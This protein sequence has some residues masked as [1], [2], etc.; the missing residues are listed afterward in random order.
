VALGSRVVAILSDGFESPDIILGD[1]IPI[2]CANESEL[3]RT[4]RSRRLDGLLLPLGAR[5]VRNVEILRRLW[6]EGQLTVAIVADMRP[7]DRVAASQ[8]MELLLLGMDVRPALRLKDVESLR[9][10]LQRL[11]TRGTPTARE[12]LLSSLAPLVPIE[13]TE[14]LVVACVLGGVRRSAAEFSASLSIGRSALRT[15]LSTHGL[16]TPTG[17]LGLIAGF[18]L[19]YHSSVLDMSLV[20]ASRWAQFDSED[21]FRNYLKARTGI[22]PRGWKKLGIRASLQIVLDRLRLS[23]PTSVHNSAS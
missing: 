22:G 3:V 4:L 16:P 5:A 1:A 11:P 19:A 8:L 6:H 10:E 17:M 18:H 21:A 12:F 13:L 7:K 14:I 20:E 23:H 2:P 9:I 15:I